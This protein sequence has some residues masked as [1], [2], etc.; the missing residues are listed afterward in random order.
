MENV[1]SREG[2]RIGAFWPIVAIITVGIAMG[3][4]VYG[5]ESIAP[6]VHDAFH[7]FRHAA[8]FPCH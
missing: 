6:G 3:V 5:L 7:D 2:A 4:V 1:A 8:G